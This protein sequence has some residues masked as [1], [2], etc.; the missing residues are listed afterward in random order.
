MSERCPCPGDDSDLFRITD[1]GIGKYIEFPSDTIFMESMAGNESFAKGVGYIVAQRKTGPGGQPESWVYEVRPGM[2]QAKELFGPLATTEEGTQ[3]TIFGS[4]L[5]SDGI[6]Y[7]CCFNR[8]SLLTYDLKN[9]PASGAPAL[10]NLEI[11]GLPSP[12]DLC[13]DPKDEKTIYVCGGTF[14]NLAVA[15][16][17]NSAY[18]QVFKVTVNEDSTGAQVETVKDGLDTLA[19]IEV[20]GNDVWVAQLY[21]LI[22]L[23]QTN[24]HE[25]TIRWKGND[26]TGN[27]WLADNI[28]TFEVAEGGE[29]LILC[30]AYSTVPQSTVKNI[31]QRNCAMSMVLFG[32]QVM[33][34][35][36]KCEGIREALEDPE[37]SLGFSNTFIK[38]GVDPAP[39]RIMMMKPDGSKCY[40]FEI[41]LV[42]TRADHDPW[43]PEPEEKPGQ[44]R[45]FFN[46][47]VTHSSHLK[48]EDGDGYVVCIN[49]EQPRI[50]LLKD[51]T[52][53]Q[54]IAKKNERE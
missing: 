44:M 48:S 5:T 4:A 20:I 35:V 28:D 22:S 46:E 6:L 49:F 52:F 16:F 1:E 9:L 33:T 47:Q 18:G 7:L 51:D 12:N 23:D 3:T 34:A 45:H 29:K 39:I 50:L 41:D 25:S 19:G 32:Y 15:K 13:L 2:D 43:E 21:D 40:H 36:A 14:R 42:Q 26:G 24:N 8:N 37:V 54:C 38:E 11:D 10:C 17:T 53:K 30:P 31:M 27:V